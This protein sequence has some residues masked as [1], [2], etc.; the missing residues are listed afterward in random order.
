MLEATN[1]IELA[2]VV[3][4]ELEAVLLCVVE[5]EELGVDCALD[6]TGLE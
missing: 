6:D 3:E 2:D 5:T 1:V 4:V